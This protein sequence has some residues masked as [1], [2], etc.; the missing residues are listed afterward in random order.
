MLRPGIYSNVGFLAS[1][2]TLVAKQQIHVPLVTMKK[3]A[4]SHWHGW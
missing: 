1:I 4:T 2:A 3:S